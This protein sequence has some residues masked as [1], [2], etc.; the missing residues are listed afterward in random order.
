[1]SALHYVAP[2][3]EKEDYVSRAM[4]HITPFLEANLKTA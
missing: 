2:V 1:V 3:G 4:G